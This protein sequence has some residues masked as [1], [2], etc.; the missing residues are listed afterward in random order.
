MKISILAQH[1]FPLPYPNLHTGD[2]VII[3]LMRVLEQL[4]HTVDFY[5]PEGSYQP[6]TGKL[7]PIKCSYGQTLPWAHECE[8]DCYS[9]YGEQLKQS[10]IIHDFTV[11]KYITE[12]LY[13]EN[14]KKVIQTIMVGAWQKDY[15]PKNLVVWS[16]SHQNRVIRGYSD[17]IGTLTP[18]I[19]GHVGK[20][21][22]EKVRVVNGG[23]NTDFYSPGG[24]KDDYFLWMGRWHEVRGYRLTINLAKQTG[25]K[26][27]MAGEHPDNELFEYQKKCA[28]EAIELAK[29]CNNI[30]FEWLPKDPNHHVAKRELYRRALGFILTTQFQEPFGLSQ[31]ESMACGTP[32]I[33]TNY[34]SMPEI[35]IDGKT[36]FICKNDIMNFAIAVKLVDRLDNKICREIAVEKYDKKVMGQNYLREYNDIISG[37]SK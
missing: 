13:Q 28:L 37:G 34:G 20:P 11:E 18:D 1:S 17:Y 22:K 24:T 7:F 32:V 6:S 21:V 30:K 4:G 25:I 33:S 19:A 31:V 27:I 15:S 16:Q 5:A 29:G 3:D 23:I 12:K 35:I 14:Y 26:L 2:Q 10:D 9:K 36:G 8:E